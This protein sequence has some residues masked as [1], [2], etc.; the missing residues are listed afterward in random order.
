[1]KNKQGIEW[2]FAEFKIN[3]GVSEER[4]EEAERLIQSAERELGRKLLEDK[5]VRII[6]AQSGF[7]PEIEND[8]QMR[9]LKAGSELETKGRELGNKTKENKGKR[10]QEVLVLGLRRTKEGD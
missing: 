2:L 10:L 4:W 9:A 5:E 8:L 7:F 6:L 3:Y 1:M